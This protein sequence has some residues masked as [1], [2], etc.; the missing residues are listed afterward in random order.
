M[1][2]GGHGAAHRRRRLHEIAHG[3]RE[4]GVDAVALVLREVD[5]HPV[6]R[7]LP[8]LQDQRPLLRLEPFVEVVDG[9]LVLGLGE[10]VGERYAGVFLECLAPL[11][12]LLHRHGLSAQ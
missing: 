12:Q 9:D 7:G 3:L 11:T 4:D 1:V 6:V 8:L 2:V 10:Q 5:R